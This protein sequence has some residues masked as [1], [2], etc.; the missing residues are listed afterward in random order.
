MGVLEVKFRISICGDGKT[1]LDG[2][3]GR[4]N[5]VVRLTAN[6]DASHRNTESYK[7]AFKKSG[8]LTAATLYVIVHDQR[9][10][11]YGNVRG[12]TLKS[13]L[14]TVLDPQDM[15]SLTAYQHSDFG[16]GFKIEHPNRFIFDQKKPSMALPKVK[17]PPGAVVMVR[18]IANPIICF[19]GYQN[20][21]LDTPIICRTNCLIYASHTCAMMQR[22]PWLLEERRAKKHKKEELP[23]LKARAGEGANHSNQ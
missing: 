1:A 12:M 8:G 5:Q 4:M 13:V 23:S 21:R 20:Y 15:M 14:W 18:C 2:A 3:F 6:S 22:M 10:R 19:L 17:S 9:K 16:S 11:M 7:D